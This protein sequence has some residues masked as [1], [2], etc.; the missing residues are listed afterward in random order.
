[1]AELWPRM[2]RPTAAGSVLVTFQKAGAIFEVDRQG[3]T[4]WEYKVDP[5]RLPY[6]ALRLPNGNTVIGL[7]DPGE[8]IEVDTGGK[9]V[10]SIGGTNGRLRF[11]WIAGIALLPSGG[12]MIADFTSHRV[13]EVDAASMPVHELRDLPWAVASIAV[14]PAEQ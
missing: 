14:M 10:R 3:N 6:Q 2:S 1:M 7:V 5:S 8:V 12:M 11:G 13:V 9:T 4:V